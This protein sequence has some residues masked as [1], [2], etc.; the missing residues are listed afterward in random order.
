MLSFG[1][2]VPI[3]DAS[4]THGCPA[5]SRVIGDRPVFVDTERLRRRSL[6]PDRSPPGGALPPLGPQMLIGRTELLERAGL[7]PRRRTPAATIEMSKPMSLR[8]RLRPPVRRAP[9]SVH[10]VPSTSRLARFGRPSRALASLEVNS[11]EAVTRNGVNYAAF[12]KRFGHPRQPSH[13]PR[14]TAWLAYPRVQ[15]LRFS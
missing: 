8:N 12:L 5:V 4:T 14:E 6:G 3:G 9:Q 2:G 13:A 7:S 15:R 11:E 1:R 10:G